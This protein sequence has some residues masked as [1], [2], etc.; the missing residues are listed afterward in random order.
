MR[1]TN[2][3][4]FQ[5]TWAPSFD[6]TGR[7][8]LVIIIKATYQLTAPDFALVLADK[9]APIIEADIT[10]GDPG[11]SA[12]LYESD[13]A[14]FKPY[15][16]VLVNGCAYAPFGKATKEVPV[17]LK[18]TN[19]GNV[20]LD[21]QFIVKGN[22]YWVL[23]IISFSASTPE[24]F[25]K[26]PVSYDNAFGGMDKSNP[27][28]LRF[29]P[30][31]PVGKGYSYHK[32]NLTGCL[33]ANTEQIG[34]P[35]QSPNGNYQPMAFGAIARSWPIRAKYAG[36]YDEYWTQNV[37]PFWPEDFDYRFFQSAP[38]NQQV[39]Y[40][41]GGEE[42][43]LLNFSRYPIIHFNVPEQ[44]I[45]VLFIPYKGHKQQLQSVVDTLI[46]EPELERI[47][48]TSRVALPLKKNIHDIKEVIIGDISRAM[49]HA[50]RSPHKTYYTSLAELVKAKQ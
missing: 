16:D 25:L 39:P 49:Q 37:M 36:T 28:H 31:N 45:P 18:V 17:Q 10:T 12:T 29:Y 13:F 6:K 24:P 43:T 8:Q 20:L 4:A 27:E 30:N 47:I 50:Q 32:T 46:I 11:F 14:S 22:R 23:D 42:I 1:L 9:Q 19:K 3:T 44:R 2:Q 38:P 40:L 26:M 7:G 15:C 5:A 33:L 21:K 41:K 48:M 34:H 35:I